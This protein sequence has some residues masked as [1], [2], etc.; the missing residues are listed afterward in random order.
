MMVVVVVK[1]AHL[2]KSQQELWDLD[3]GTVVAVD[4]DAV[5]AVDDEKEQIRNVPEIVFWEIASPP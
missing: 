3:D 4:A 2:A 1:N 5:V